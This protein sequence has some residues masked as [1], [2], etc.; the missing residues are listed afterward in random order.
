MIDKNDI[1]HLI[2][3]YINNVGGCRV[4][5]LISNLPSVVN[6]YEILIAIGNY[7]INSLADELYKECRIER[8]QYIV[9][10]EIVEMSPK[11]R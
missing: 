3:A 8:I 9:P 11:K 5:D 7:N 6:N 10:S 2:V 1:K 4:S